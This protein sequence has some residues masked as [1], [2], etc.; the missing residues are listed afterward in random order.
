MEYCLLPGGG[1]IWS[2]SFGLVRFHIR[3]MIE[4][5]SSLLLSLF[6][7]PFSTKNAKRVLKTCIAINSY[8]IGKL[9]WSSELLYQSTWSAD[10]C[11]RVQTGWRWTWL[12]RRCWVAYSWRRASCKR[13]D[14]DTAC[15]SRAVARFYAT[16]WSRPSAW[17]GPLTHTKW[18]YY[19]YFQI[20]NVN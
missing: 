18:H 10:W 11:A 12:C 9:Q 6:T 4:R 7:F 19:Y 16:M 1:M 3:L 20:L 8:Q 14:V 5:S 17:F 13:F 2:S 15:Q